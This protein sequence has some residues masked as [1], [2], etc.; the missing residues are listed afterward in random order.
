MKP[1]TT[2]RTG[3]NLDRR[4]L[5]SFKTSIN[6]KALQAELGTANTKLKEL[7]KKSKTAGHACRRVYAQGGIAMV[8]ADLAKKYFEIPELRQKPGRPAIKSFPTRQHHFPFN[9]SFFR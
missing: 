7:E 4:T 2:W 3:C 8:C 6:N 9:S 5:S 1:C